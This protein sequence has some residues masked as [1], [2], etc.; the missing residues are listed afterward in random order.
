MSLK[1]QHSSVYLPMRRLIWLGP[2]RRLHINRSCSRDPWPGSRLIAGIASVALLTAEMASSGEMRYCCSL[3]GSSV[4]TIV[5]GAKRS[6]Y[7]A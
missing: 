4:T 5:L 7:L 3:L 6:L 1:Q 2:F